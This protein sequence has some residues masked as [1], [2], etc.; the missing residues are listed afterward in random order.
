MAIVGNLDNL[1]LLYKQLPH[2]T[3]QTVFTWLPQLPASGQDCTF[4]HPHFPTIKA[5]LKRISTTRQNQVKYES[6]KLH[7]DIHLCLSGSEIIQ[8]APTDQLTA[9]SQNATDDYLLYEP[10]RLP[11]QTIIMQPRTVAILFPPDAHLPSL[12][13]TASNFVQKIIVKVP[14]HLIT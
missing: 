11:A 1:A 14:L 6:H 7:I 8:V 4:I 2:P 10:P 3:W 12:P 13:H 5:H 9:I